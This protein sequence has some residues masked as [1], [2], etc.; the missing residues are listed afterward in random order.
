MGAHIF[1]LLTDDQEGGQAQ[2]GA[3]CHSDPEARTS[4]VDVTSDNQRN[5]LIRMLHETGHSLGLNDIDRK[6]ENDLC[7]LNDL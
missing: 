7:R 3:V 6:N 5:G 1:Q 2:N 4:A